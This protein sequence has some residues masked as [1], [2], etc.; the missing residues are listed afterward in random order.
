MISEDHGTMV[1]PQEDVYDDP[2]FGAIVTLNDG[3][4]GDLDPGG[5]VKVILGVEA[6][7]TAVGT[8]VGSGVTIAVTVAVTP[9]PPDPPQE[10][11]K[12]KNNNECTGNMNCTDNMKCSNNDECSGNESC[13]GTGTDGKSASMEYGSDSEADTSWW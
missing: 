10:N 4:S 9:D 3:E 1:L 6:V 11:D 7:K 5:I 2:L 8:A 13:V 12:C